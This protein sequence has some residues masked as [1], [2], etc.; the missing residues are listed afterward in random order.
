VNNSN[1]PPSYSHGRVLFLVF[2]NKFLV[3]DKIDTGLT[4]HFLTKIIIAHLTEF[5]PAGFAVLK[6]CFSFIRDI[7]NIQ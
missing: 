1:N 6:V 5:F 2:N 7:K 3:L 4:A